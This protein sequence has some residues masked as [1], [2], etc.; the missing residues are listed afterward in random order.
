MSF[1]RIT[2]LLFANTTQPGVVGS[3]P[4]LAP[5]VYDARS[6]D[7]QAADIWSLAIIYCCM[8]LRR[9]PWKLPRVT[10]NSFKLFAAE[11]TPGHDPERN[12]A[13]RAHHVPDGHSR[14]GSV[15]E[16]TPPVAMD[17]R[18]V[19]GES[20]TTSVAPTAADKP[21]NNP[22]TT[23]LAPPGPSAP[24]IGTA[25]AT[26]ATDDTKKEVIKG[27]WRILRLLPRESRR[28][29]HRMLQIPPSLRA[30]MDEILQE[31]WVA[32]AVICQ[33]STD[34]VVTHAIDHIHTLEPPAQQAVNP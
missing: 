1:G 7:A 21:D 27:P 12:L 10:D 2:G 30:T 8:T 26:T 4:Y 22:S 34:G 31:P 16:S 13:G 19:P 17:G 3:D 20:S 33:Q 18:G 9:F 5:E 28:I 29:I 6:Y 15:P 23:A 32:D 24:S 25:S 14:S 11:P